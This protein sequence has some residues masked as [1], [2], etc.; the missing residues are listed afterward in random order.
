M[1][2]FDLIEQELSVSLAA[3][4]E[5]LLGSGRWTMERIAAVIGVTTETLRN[6]RKGKVNDPRFIGVAK[7]HYLA[8]RPLNILPGIAD[9]GALAFA[10]A[11]AAAGLTLG[12]VEERA[13]RH[14]QENPEE[15]TAAL[16]AVRSELA[17]L[18]E[19]LVAQLNAKRR[20]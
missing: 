9:T 10:A 12:L 16:G 11:P 3:C 15:M 1:Q 2:D 13:G 19:D 7:L 8:C 17:E 20:A 6:W 4:L 18:Q 5:T 14:W